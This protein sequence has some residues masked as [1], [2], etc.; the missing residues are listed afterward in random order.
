MTTIR[1]IPATL[2]FDVSI[3]SASMP[4]LFD[5]SLE[6]TICAKIDEHV[7][8]RIPDAENISDALQSNR[9]FLR[10]VRDWVIESM[11]TGDIARQVGDQIDITEVVDS[12]GLTNESIAE[13]NQFMRKLTDSPKFHNI[14]YNSVGRLHDD[15]NMRAIITEKIESMSISIAN[16]VAEKVMTMIANKISNTDV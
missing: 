4:G 3:D 8:N 15:L 1:L 7:T 12:L 9:D 14:V 5:Q 16:D 13:N 6:T 11:D 2:E 10:R